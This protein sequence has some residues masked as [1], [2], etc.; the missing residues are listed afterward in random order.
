MQFRKVTASKY[1]GQHGYTLRQGRD[2]SFSI[3]KDNVITNWGTSFNTVSAA[4][5]FLDQHDYIRATATSLP[6]SR[7]DL[8]F[9]LDMYGMDEYKPGL[10]RSETA[11]LYVPSSFEEG[12][13]VIIHPRTKRHSNISVDDISALFN[14]LDDLAE[15]DIFSSV[16]YRGTNLRTIL[17]KRSNGFKKPQSKKR[18]SRDITKNLVRVKSSNV[19]SYG[20]EIKNADDKIGDVY[21]QFKGKNGGPGDIYCYYDVDLNTWRKVLS[22]PSKGHAVWQHLRNN[23]LY[24]KLTG[25][26]KGK[27]PNA[28]NY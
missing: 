11:D 2:G 21:V 9:V 25:D 8:N 22:A 3:F 4:E 15:D 13:P 10:Y 28:V 26:K 16:S 7:N 5:R 20:V 14:N 24:S 12:Q 19:W 6:I 23:F 18:S 17:A 1:I 27:L